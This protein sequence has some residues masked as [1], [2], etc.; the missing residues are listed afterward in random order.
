M[1]V[2]F[3]LFVLCVFDLCVSVFW[4]REVFPRG[5]GAYGVESWGTPHFPHNL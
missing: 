5:R 1:A 2:S 4:G 3:V